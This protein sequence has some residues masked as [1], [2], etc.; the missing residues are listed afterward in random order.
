MAIEI[1]KSNNVISIATGSDVPRS[2]FGA[3]GAAGKFYPNGKDENGDYIGILL[4]I[5]GDSY[6]LYWDEL[7]I[8]S[9]TPTNFSDA[10][11]LLRTLFS[12]LV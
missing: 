2:Y 9:S 3:Y 1:S 11:S 7:V 10:M 5:G 12:N 4:I 6:Q 8:D